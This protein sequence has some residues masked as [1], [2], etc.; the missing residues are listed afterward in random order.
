MNIYYW[1]VPLESKVQRRDVIKLQT[2]Q[3][4]TLS[5]IAFE[6]FLRKE[7]QN[8]GSIPFLGQLPSTHPS[9]MI[10]LRMTHPEKTLLLS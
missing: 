10:Q 4:V 6:Y 7:N 8:W 2:K 9:T 5:S 1:R 3:F